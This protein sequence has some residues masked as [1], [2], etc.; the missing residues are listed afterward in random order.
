LC[1]VGL[2][3]RLCTRLLEVRLRRR[4]WLLEAGL[5]LGLWTR[6]LGVR[7]RRRLDVRLR[8]SLVDARLRLLD[9]G[10]G[11]HGLLVHRPALL[12][13]RHVRLRPRRLRP[14]AG[15]DAALRRISDG[16]RM[17]HAVVRLRP[18]ACDRHVLRESG[19]VRRLAR[20]HVL[21]RLRTGLRRHTAPGQVLR[22]VCGAVRRSDDGRVRSHDTYVAR[23]HLRRMRG[24]RRR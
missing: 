23:V 11:R 13:D 21:A 24:V 2:I 8:V 17:R 7:L 4:T 9:S 10:V 18:R 15:L 19:R 14:C 16:R 3:L 22:G 20:G 1:E 5:I 12:R 6:L